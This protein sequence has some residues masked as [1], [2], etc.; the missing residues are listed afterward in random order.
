MRPS[1]R[2]RGV[3]GGRVRG[4]AHGL[5]PL[6]D[7]VQARSVCSVRKWRFSHPR[8]TV[9]LGYRVVRTPSVSSR[10]S[11]RGEAG[12]QGAATCRR[13]PP[14]CD[15]D[16]D[17]LFRLPVPSGSAASTRIN[18]G[19]PHQRSPYQRPY[20][21]PRGPPRRAWR[22]AGRRR[23]HRRRPAARRRRPTS[24][25]SRLP[26]TRKPP[27]A[28]IMDYGKFKYEAAQKAKEA[29]RNQANTILKEVRFRLKIDKHDYE[30]KRKRAEGFLQGGD[31]VKAMILFRGR[32]QSRPDQG[33]RLLQRFAE[34]VV[35]VR[36]RRVHPHD[37][38]PQHGHGHR[39]PEEQVRGEGRGRSPQGGEQ[40]PQAP[41]RPTR[42]RPM[43]RPTHRQKRAS[44]TCPS[45]RPTPVPR[46]V[47][48][49]P[50]PAR[51]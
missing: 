11:S 49:S 24:T 23:P 43:H 29:R 45:R 15:R 35:R 10:R 5:I 42:R 50:A 9:Q 48:R 16:A 30:T 6:L 32:E 18:R 20:P 3:V 40:G 38:R 17:L 14:W 44:K 7:I 12:S 26:P 4:V 25:W 37:R 28:K 2:R 19:V 1:T 36:Q 47:S 22:R 27:V 13:T 31:K 21:S 8:L 46:S 41:R 33:V 34:D 51:S 39:P